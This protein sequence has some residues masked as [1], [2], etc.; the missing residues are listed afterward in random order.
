VLAPKNAPQ[1]SNVIVSSGDAIVSAA[2]NEGMNLEGGAARAHLVEAIFA[3]A[4]DLNASTS[5]FQ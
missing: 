1:A 2:A 4:V 5:N 3:R